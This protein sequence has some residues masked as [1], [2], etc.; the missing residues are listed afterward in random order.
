MSDLFHD[1]MREGIARWERV[2][3]IFWA[4]LNARQHIFMVLTKRPANMVEFF[5][6]WLYNTDPIDHIYWGVTAENQHRWDER[7]FFLNMPVTTF[8]SLEPL[9]SHI[10][11]GMS[12]APGSLEADTPNLVIVGAETGPGRRKPEPAWIKSIVGQ[13][14]DAHVPIFM[15]DNLREFWHGPLIQEYPK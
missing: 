6:S 9:L 7:S 12:G 1:K 5:D 3:N 4:M 11:L 8:V 14:F 13:C 15:K 10:D 2:Y